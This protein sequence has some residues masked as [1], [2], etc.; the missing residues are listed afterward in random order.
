MIKH[1]IRIPEREE[2]KNEKEKKISKIMSIFFQMVKNMSL[3]YK[4]RKCQA[5]K[6]ISSK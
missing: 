2:R 5:E 6:T 4:F 1:F 3:Q